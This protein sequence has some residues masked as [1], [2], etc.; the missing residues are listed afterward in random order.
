MNRRRFGSN[1]DGTRNNTDGG[2]GGGNS[3]KNTRPRSNRGRRGG[4][5]GGGGNGDGRRDGRSD[6]SRNNTPAPPRLSVPQIRQSQQETTIANF[7][8]SELSYNG[9]DRL[10]FITDGEPI[11]TLW[12]RILKRDKSWDQNDVRIFVSSALVATD[13]RTGYEVE[14]IVTELGNPESGLK[15]LREIIN[16]P[17]MSC[18]AG[19]DNNVLSFQHVVLPLLGLFTRTAITE[20]ILE[21]Y[22][23]AIF[24]VVYLNL[25]STINDCILSFFLRN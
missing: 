22:V 13:R 10:V 15:R 20:C 5:G 2:D 25:V 14:D 21:K 24:M 23:H 6:Q 7:S 12:K 19:L 8:S 3:S 11:I 1:N 16:F 9:S 17:S 18:D 4:G